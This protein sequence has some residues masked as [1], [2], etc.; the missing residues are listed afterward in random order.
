MKPIIDAAFKHFRAILFFFTFIMLFGSYAY[1]MI[2]KESSPDVP[3]PF[4]YISVSYEG[5]SPED[6]E[7]LLI[8]PLE[9]E[10]QGLEGLKELQATALEGRVNVILEFD[11]GFDN[12]KALQNVREKVDT[13]KSQFPNGTDDPIIQEI[14][15]ALFPILTINFSGDVLQST[16][17]QL[18]NYLKDEI[19]RLPEILEAKVIGDR[20]D[21]I[22]IIIDP[23]MIE[24]YQISYEEVILS[25]Q[26]NNRLVAA[27]SID[28]GKGCLSVKVPAVID[29][30]NDI[31]NYPIKVLENQTVL[32][33]DIATIQKTYKDPTSIA[34][35]NSKPTIALQISKRIGAN[36]IETVEATK[37]IINE[38]SKY[39]KD[40]IDIY[41]S[42]D[43]SKD[44]KEMLGDLQNNIISAII[45]V[46]LVIIAV[47]GIRSSIVVGLSIPSSFLAGILI[48]YLMGYTINI[49]VLFSLILVV[50]MLVDG[51]IIVVELANRY[52]QQGYSLFTSYAMSAKRMSWPVIASTATTLAVFVPLIFWPGMIGNFMKFLPITVIIT[53]GSSLFMALIFIPVIGGVLGKKNVSIPKKNR[54]NYFS[55]QYHKLLNVILN[56]YVLTFVISCI[57][58]VFIYIFYGFF[59]HGVEFFPNIEP[60]YAQVHIRSRGDSSIYEKDMLV[61]EI[62]QE[63]VK[64]PELFSVYSNTSSELSS[65]LFA[66]DV[67]GV[68]QLEFIPW[69]TRRP[70]SE[71]FND[72]RNR[73]KPF[74]GTIIELHK[75]EEG[76]PQSKVIDLQLESNNNKNLENAVKHVLSVMDTI[77]GFK[78]I[79]DDLPL[80]GIEWR[81]EVDRT[82][83]AHQQA[84]TSVIG[85]MVQMLTKGL[86]IS[87]YRPDEVDEEI[88]INIRFPIKK[89]N[90]DSMKRLRI[91]TSIGFVP[92]ENFVKFVPKQKK[93]AIY[94]SGGKRVMHVKAN[95]QDNLLANEQLAKLKNSLNKAFLKDVNLTIK[96][97]DEQ[98]REA[99]SFLFKAFCIAL[100]LMLIILILQFNNFYQVFLVLSA[101]IFSTAGVL[102]GLLVTG[103]PLEIVMIGIALIA[104]SGIVINNN[105]VLIDTYNQLRSEGVQVREAIIKTCQQRLRPIFLTA[106]TTILGLMPMMLT[107]NIDF[108]N[109]EVTI[110]A[111]STQWWTQLSTAIVF[112]LS[113]ATIVSL[114]ITPS[115]LMI[116]SKKH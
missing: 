103:R 17:V 93:S 112:G 78:D 67:I 76:P 49:V 45:L 88:D 32:F 21:I 18:A 47:L 35:L 53:L 91:F 86:K 8:K 44:V 64:M 62:E 43:G 46:M 20:E 37:N 27:G 97:E 25:L 108:I 66:K 11:A 84:N 54:T 41:Y 48:L 19:E 22:E 90:L 57:I 79:E 15:F 81:L 13:A 74:V 39:W 50:G 65:G 83:A 96:G 92:I 52:Q 102:I 26:S 6:G 87:T 94:R 101:I 3:V 70:V 9:K 24:T 1:Y 82:K 75:Q 42:Q 5:I 105:I 77:G 111:P 36:I 23:I 114:I 60:D 71:I 58:L 34:R 113:F 38:N 73:L 115:L 4:I 40:K 68:I 55:L 30:L 12:T 109:N 99:V 63:L 7:R 72:I 69:N 10:L 61:R 89:R 106:I 110:G 29:N 31:L 51:A 2:P 104:L 100:F 98:Q 95:V 33:K 14:N 56:H 59:N 85:S 116:K 107:I 28:T 16:L 80:P